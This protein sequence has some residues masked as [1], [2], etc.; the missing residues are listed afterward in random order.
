M[1]VNF[2]GKHVDLSKAIK[3]QIEEKLSKLDRYSVTL[4]E[5]QVLLKKEK[6]LHVA[7]ITVV[8][9]GVNIYGEGS[10]EDSFLSACDVAFEKVTKQL[11]KKKGKIKDHKHKAHRTSVK[12]LEES[13]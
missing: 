4:I 1:K 10:C 6:Y 5:S 9:K 12:H 2:I 7:E 13:E 8:G 11:V 3:L